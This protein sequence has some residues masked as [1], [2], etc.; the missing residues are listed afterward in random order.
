MKPL[1]IL[2]VDDEKMN[3][4]VL[5]HFLSDEY[6]IFA[7]RSGK[8]ALKVAAANRPDLIILD[9]IM[10]EMNGYEV[11]A[12]LKESEGTA[13]IPVV[14]ITSLDN[15]ENE[16][17]GL[18][19]GAV[20]Y[21]TKPFNATIVKARVRT[22]MKVTRQLRTL[23]SKGMIDAPTGLPNR[24]YFD[25]QCRIEWLRAIQRNSSIHLWRVDLAG[26][27]PD[28]ELIG[29]VAHL[30]KDLLNSH[31]SGFVARID[32]TRF[33]LLLPG[34]D[35]FCVETFT[36]E[37]HDRFQNAPLFSASGERLTASVESFFA[38][39]I[40]ENSIDELLIRAHRSS[41]TP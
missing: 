36:D 35:G 10:P 18:Q 4:D 15:A 9:I 14:V 24:R 31:S 11:I 23:E 29:K 1:S 39:P 26:P 32:A 40:P 8:T 21:I 34:F 3:L 6:E 20:D 16:A 38:V 30:L 22:L 37:I 7:V 41:V 33:G 12:R 17:K 5:S 27:P 19:L 13:R 28:D 25:L 2:L